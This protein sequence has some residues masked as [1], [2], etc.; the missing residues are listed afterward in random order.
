VAALVAATD[1]HPKPPG[2][3]AAALVAVADTEQGGQELSRWTATATNPAKPP[4]GAA[5]AL[6]VDVG[7][8]PERTLRIKPSPVRPRDE[9]GGI[10][11]EETTPHKW[12]P[13]P[14]SGGRNM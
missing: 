3:Q 2:G 12:K 4:D 14:K 8:P 13:G 7:L 11:R 9:G 6:V 10:R 1:T 5:A